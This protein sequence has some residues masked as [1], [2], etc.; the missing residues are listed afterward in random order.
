MNLNKLSKRLTLGLRHNPML[1]F[2]R[3]LSSDGFIDIN[4]A[5]D[6]LNIT[7]SDLNYIVNNDDKNRFEIKDDKI[8]AR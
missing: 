4:I 8:R 1:V 3:E 5:L 6:T 2:N 7:I